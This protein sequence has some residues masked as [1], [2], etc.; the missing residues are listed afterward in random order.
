[1]SDEMEMKEYISRE[2]IQRFTQK[3]DLQAFRIL[4]MNWAA[5]FLIFAFV[6]FWTNP[7]SILLALPLLA[8]RQLGLSIIMHDCG[9]NI[10]FSTKEKNAFYGQWF[11]AN[12]VLQDLHSYARGHLNHHRMAGTKQDP[13]LSNY[14]DYPVSKERFKRKVIRD[15]TGQT[16]WK[17]FKLILMATKMAFS[18]D[19][20]ARKFSKPFVQEWFVQLVLLAVLTIT[21]SPWL[22]LLWLASWLSVYM[23]IVRLRQIAEHAAVD[24]LYELDPRKNTRTTIPNWLE[25]VFIAPNYVNYHLEHHFLASVPCYHLPA[26][27]KLLKERGAY[28]NTKNIAYGYRQVFREALV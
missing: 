16:G 9:H 4:F 28:K 12:A 7:L 1:M 17:L 21:M 20:N 19:E 25:R 2:E 23:L 18:K 27:H 3:K 11:A 26:L 10:F 5:I 14:R 15:I 24:D 8:G 6:Y 13:D 22:Y